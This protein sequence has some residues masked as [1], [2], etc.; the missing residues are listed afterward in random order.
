MSLLERSIMEVTF[1][2]Q[3]GK[4]TT[5]ILCGHYI[6]PIK[7][8]ITPPHCHRLGEI[9]ILL[10]GS[11]DYTIDGE[12]H[13]FQAGDAVYIPPKVFHGAQC[14]T[15][16]TTFCTVS[17]RSNFKNLHLC[18]LSP[19]L[20]DGLNQA[21]AKGVES[22]SLEP[23]LPF[24]YLLLSSLLPIPHPAIK[25]SLDFDGMLLRYLDSNYN[26]NITL[27]SLAKIVG[28]SPKQVQ[29]IIQNET[30][31]TFLEELTARRMQAARYLEEN[32]NMSAT[33]IAHYVGYNSYSGYWKAR[34]N[35]LDSQK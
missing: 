13:V 10:S 14:K 25:E 26:E 4:T 7:L 2:M 19:S 34:K 1:S 8:G 29:R 18:H 11:A 28:L 35:Y 23:L 16:T 24:F 33:E 17:V 22:E 27:A 21:I 3:L 30:G 15:A 6:S 12:D 9:H 20:L 5:E 32:T 31:N